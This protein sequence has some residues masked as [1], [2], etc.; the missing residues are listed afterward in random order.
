MLDQGVGTSEE[1]ADSLDGQVGLGA[2]GRR[3]GACFFGV[4]SATIERAHWH[5]EDETAW[6]VVGVVTAVIA[7]RS[8]KKRMVSTEDTIMP[9]GMTQW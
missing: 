6:T 1:I 2:M 5:G 7:F 8:I 3:A 9:T 4:A